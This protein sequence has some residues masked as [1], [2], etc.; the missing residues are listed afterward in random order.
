LIGYATSGDELVNKQCV[1]IPASIQILDLMLSINNVG[2]AFKR[3][4]DARQRL[5]KLAKK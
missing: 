1:R 5:G 2:Q 3:S 4:A